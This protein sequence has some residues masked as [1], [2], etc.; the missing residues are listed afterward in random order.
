MYSQLA[1]PVY[2]CSRLLPCIIT[3][4]IFPLAIFWNSG[5][6]LW[7]MGFLSSQP[8]RIFTVRGRDRCF[9]RV[10]IA[11]YSF[12]GRLSRAE[13]APLLQIASIGQPQLRSTKSD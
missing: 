8:V 11:S 12:L 3:A 4:A 1:E 5:M 9:V 13:P 6:S 7:P 10:W 2:L